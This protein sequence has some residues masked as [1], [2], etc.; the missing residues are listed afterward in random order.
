[1]TKLVNV[2]DAQI[3]TATITV[4]ALTI[5]KRQVTL[6]VFRQL[7][8]EDILI[9]GS[10]WPDGDF[11]ASQF[12]LDGEQEAD[13]NKVY[14]KGIAWGRVNYHCDP[15]CAQA[16][17]HFHIIWQKGDELR[18]CIVWKGIQHRWF[19]PETEEWERFHRAWEYD[20][21]MDELRKTGMTKREAQESS[22]MNTFMDS[23]YGRVSELEQLD[24]LFI[25]V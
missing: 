8:D 23:Y 1:M 18:R 14:L 25:A 5:G 10:E 9:D 19:N 4:K 24:Q 21:V 3:L 20:S 7:Q 6:A 11:L 12:T 17:P 13:S 2:E 16:S 15:K 22:G